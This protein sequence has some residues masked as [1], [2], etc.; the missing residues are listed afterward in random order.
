MTAHRL[1]LILIITFAALVLGVASIVALA[2][3]AGPHA[4]R[5]GCLTSRRKGNGGRS[6]DAGTLRGRANVVADAQA[7][8]AIGSRS[9]ASHVHDWSELLL[10]R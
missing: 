6:V 10:F 8:S 7:W 9:P 1:R 3:A 4:Q 5:E 2:A